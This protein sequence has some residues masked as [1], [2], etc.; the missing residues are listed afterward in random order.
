MPSSFKGLH[1]KIV[2]ML[3]A[4]VS[5]SWQRPTRIQKELNFVP[6]SFPHLGQVMVS[7]H[8]KYTCCEFHTLPPLELLP[9]L[10]W[11]V[12]AKKENI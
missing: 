6:K 3:E 7:G 9:H 10:N 11:L 2:Y 1:G 5:R 4:K 8:Y 12:A